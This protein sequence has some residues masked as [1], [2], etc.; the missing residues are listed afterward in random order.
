[1]NIFQYILVSI[2]VSIPVKQCPKLVVNHPFG[3]GWNPTY[4]NADDW[5][6]V[7]PQT[8]QG[9]APWRKSAAAESLGL[10]LDGMMEP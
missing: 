10:E 4:K 8:A 5:G 7:Y 2:P 6:M 9:T 1:M 3:N